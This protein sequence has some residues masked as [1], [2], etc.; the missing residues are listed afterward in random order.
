M[1]QYSNGTLLDNIIKINEELSKK[2]KVKIDLRTASSM[3]EEESPGG[4]VDTAKALEE[5]LDNYIIDFVN[6]NN[7]NKSILKETHDIL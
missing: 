7:S 5:K 6:L 2:L 1:T 4:K 3:N